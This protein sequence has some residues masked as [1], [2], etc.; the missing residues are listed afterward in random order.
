MAPDITHST[1]AD[2]VNSEWSA[3]AKQP[4]LDNSDIRQEVYQTTNSTPT[5]YVSP[6]AAM[7]LN[8]A[9]IAFL[10][11]VIFVPAVTILAGACTIFTRPRI[12]ALWLQKV[13]ALLYSHANRAT[14][15]PL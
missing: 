12:R 3:H 6:I 8:I 11:T 10:V 15:N 4:F 5:P 14:T 1:R 7:L 2:G 13:D 9:I